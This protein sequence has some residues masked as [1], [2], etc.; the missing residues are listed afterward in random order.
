MRQLIIAI[1][2]A[3]LSWTAHAAATEPPD[4]HFR[5][6]VLEEPDDGQWHGRQHWLYDEENQPETNAAASNPSD[7]MEYRIRVPKANAGTEIKRTWKCGQL[8]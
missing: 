3:C 6:K 1:A 7:C 5:F 8:D 2:S 4:D